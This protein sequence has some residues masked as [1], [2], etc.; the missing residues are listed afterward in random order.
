M[1]VLNQ[2]YL[3]FLKWMN[4]PPLQNY[5]GKYPETKFSFHSFQSLLF[6]TKYYYLVLAFQAIFICC[7]VRQCAPRILWWQ[8]YLLSGFMTFAGP[9]IALFMTVSISPLLEHPVDILLFSIIWLA[10]NSS[11]NDFFYRF[12]SFQPIKFIHQLFFCLFQVRSLCFGAEIGFQTYSTSLTGAFLVSI[13]NCSTDSF[14]WMFANEPRYQCNSSVN[15]TSMRRASYSKG[16]ETKD[17]ISSHSSTPNFN[18]RS[19]PTLR[20]TRFFSNAAIFRNVVFSLIYLLFLNRSIP[21]SENLNDTI[22][23]AFFVSTYLII[24]IADDILYGLYSSEGFDIT[25]LTYLGRLF[26]YYG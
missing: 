20:S 16:N 10:V 25:G 24:F 15:L 4:P 12:F 13:I 26:T 21:F 14:I 7:N 3:A 17:T 19:W 18:V 9:Y 11:T 1:N 8:S 22:V 23:K 6:F 5:N 2:S